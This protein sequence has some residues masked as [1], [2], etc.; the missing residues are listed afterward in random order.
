[1]NIKRS[2][3]A[4]STLIGM[5]AIPAI[6]CAS[7]ARPSGYLSLFLGASVPQDTDVTISEFNPVTVKNTQAQFDPGINIGGTGGYDFGFIRLE[8]EMSY[9]QGEITSVTERT[10]GN[11]YVN[12]D[13]HVG[14]FTMLMNGFFDLHN[15]SPIT[16]YLGGGMGFATVSLSNTK[17]VDANSGALN[18]RV[19]KS[20]DDTVFA[21]QAGAG[22]DV[23]L[24]RHLSLDVG[25]RYFGTSRANFTEDWPNSTNLKLASHNAAVGLRLKF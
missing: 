24:N 9:K 5:A 17:G 18:H 12:V 6:C 23:A 4:I 10:Y 19:F 21:Y 2:F 3:V 7:P 11:R 25:Y 16:P 8:G 20:D 13:G 1:M 14:A 15:D 22:V